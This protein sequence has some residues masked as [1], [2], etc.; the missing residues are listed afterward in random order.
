MQQCVILGGGFTGAALAIHLVRA[1]PRPLDI[2]LVEPR[3]HPGGGVAYSTRDPDHRVNGPIEILAIFPDDIGHF[4][5]W[6]TQSGEAAADAEALASTGQLYC[7]RASFGRYMQQLLAEHAAG[8]P[9][10]SRI[11]H[12]RA[13]ALDLRQ[14]DGGFRIA[15][16]TGDSLTADK[17]FLAAAHEPPALPREYRALNG[18]T[19]FVEDP[20]NIA[21]IEALPR[22]RDIV[23]LGTALTAADIIASLLRQDRGQD[24]EQNREWGRIYAISRRGQRPREQGVLPPIEQR[25]AR[26]ALPVP[27]FVQRHDLRASLPRPLRALDMLRALRGDIAERESRGEDWQTAFDDLRDAA[28]EIWPRLSLPDKRRALRYLRAHYDTHRFRIA[29]QIAQRLKQGEAEGRVALLRART[30]TAE[31]DADGF[32]IT[33]RVAGEEKPRIIQA[34]GIINCTG[35]NADI[36]ASANPL[37]RSALQQGLIRPDPV[38]VGIDVGDDCRAVSRAGEAVPGLWVVG[39]LTRGHFGD[40]T[41]IPQINRQILNLIPNLLG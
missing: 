40:L 30:L 23:V 12:V 19:G 25:L 20:W 16:D 9:S 37:L 6:Y 34:G 22:G 14:A 7:R 35:P 2:T 5:R 24:R 32:R 10:Q 11:R 15:L 18:Q 41:A 29:P 28:P 36:A 4:P 38:G 8:N 1:S 27:A 17:V 13:A 31:V 26:M 33:L 21:A 39:P 3:A